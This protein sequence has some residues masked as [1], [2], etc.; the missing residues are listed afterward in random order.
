VH[1]HIYYADTSDSIVYYLKNIPFKFDLY[2]T[3]DTKNKST[4]INRRFETLL[5]IKS[6]K[7]FITPN[8]GRNVAPMLVTVGK[9]LISH[10]I[11]LHIHSKKSLHSSLLDGWFEYLFQ[12]LLGSPEKILTIINQ[13]SLNKNLGILFPEPYHEIK[14]PLG[15]GVNLS[16][17]KE[18]LKRDGRKNIETVNQSFFPVG[19][20]FWCR[21]LS[22]KPLVDMNLAYEDFES[23]NGQV[24]G[25]L[26]HA[27]ERLLPTF[28]EKV[29]LT[30]QQ[31]NFTNLKSDKKKFINKIS[32]IPSIKKNKLIN[33]IAI[34]LPQFH[35]DRYNNSFWGENFTE[36]TNLKKS[37]KLFGTHYLSTPLN[38]FYDIT[39][40][41][42]QTLQ[43]DLLDIY[44]LDAFCIYF[45]WFDK[46]RPLEKGIL[47]YRDNN[48]ANKKFFLCWA[49]ENWTR[50]WNGA[51]HDVLLKQN[52][53]EEDFIEMVE[54]L[55]INYFSN[56]K[57][58]RIDNKVIFM[59]YRP[60]LIPDLYKKIV[61]MREICKKNFNLELYLG[62]FE[63][64][65]RTNPLEYNL[66]FS[67]DFSP[68]M[69]AKQLE[70]KDLTSSINFF[71][72]KYDTVLDYNSLIDVSKN[73]EFD[74]Q[75]KKF[76]SVTP[77]WDNSPRVAGTSRIFINSDPEKFYYY[78]L[79]AIKYLK[80]NF[81]KKKSF[82]FVNA[83]NEWGEGAYI[84]PDRDEGYARIEA[85]RLATIGAA[86]IP[87]ETNDINSKFK[88]SIFED[89]DILSATINGNKEYDKNKKTILIVAHY[90]CSN[91]TGAELSFLDIIKNIDQNKFNIIILLPSLGNEKYVLECINYAIL[92]YVISN[93]LIVKSFYDIDILK[94]IK[95][96]ITF[97]KVNCI[98]LNTIVHNEILEISK[99]NDIT[100]IVHC[101]EILSK[102][103]HLQTGLFRD[104]K[105][106]IYK[107]YE[108]F[109]HKNIH[110]IVNSIA[111]KN[112][113]K[114]INK[115]KYLLYNCFKILDKNNYKLFSAIRE[116]SK[117]FNICIIS[118]NDPRKGLINFFEVAKNFASSRK[119]QF[120]I[121][122]ETSEHL[123]NLF[124]K[125][126]KPENVILRGYVPN[127]C[128]TIKDLHLLLSV[129]EFHESFGRTIVE[130]FSVGI[131]VIGNNKGALPELIISNFNG[132]NC[133]S[134]E[135]I[136]KKIIFLNTSNN[137]KE[138]SKNAYKSSLRFDEKLFKIKLN[139]IVSKLI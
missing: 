124:C 76:R 133:L 117:T 94:K 39:N 24:D 54:Y 123:K 58:Y 79:N 12:K 19:F 131:P 30:T 59:I 134:I 1:A 8:R 57:Y 130:A 51:D 17:M 29:H 46:K 25:C 28:S 31:Y 107:F 129:S 122:G 78:T 128:K 6:K 100:T 139:Q 60:N 111:T 64:F 99:L 120:H 7:I 108:K 14:K 11:V 112:E 127:P 52:Y 89:T 116:K 62:Y 73:Y 66:D 90:I 104:S 121:F 109:N 61:L 103:Q 63:S 41:D 15:I 135:D 37:K 23:E 83:F 36:W 26:Q 126:E 44:N 115:K 68:N 132:F 98:Y 77:A 85:F 75:Y 92:I 113:L 93:P 119:F 88:N 138:F 33:N 95:K 3:T 40:K 86:F 48:R 91:N 82:L 50:K 67:S 114:K 9:Y 106:S 13:F 49:N 74:N 56:T 69:K 21:G 22:I 97:H 16:R 10:D 55:C 20:M 5:N 87:Y 53:T 125:F 71:N 35:N 110:F 81:I 18:L 27:I 70:C 137:Y 96:I 47:S 34:Y 65:E 72:P 45:Y 38:G 42:I 84:E 32:K 80:E 2:I 136:C 43:S 102:D 101:R 118:S 4:I 105:M